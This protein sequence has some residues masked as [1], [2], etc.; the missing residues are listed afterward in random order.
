VVNIA[1]HA[2]ALEPLETKNAMKKFATHFGVRTNEIKEAQQANQ[3]VRTLDKFHDQ[4]CKLTTL[5]ALASS[6]WSGRTSL[7]PL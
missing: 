3:Q 6:N 5:I 1:E 2:L 4:V 7:P